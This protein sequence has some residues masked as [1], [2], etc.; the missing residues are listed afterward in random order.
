MPRARATPLI[1]VD[2]LPADG[3]GMEIH[4]GLRD[5]AFAPGRTAGKG[6][7]LQEAIKLTVAPGVHL[8]G[9]V[10][11]DDRPTLRGERGEEGTIPPHAFT[12]G[13]PRENAVEPAGQRHEV[14]AG[15]SVC[16][17]EEPGLA[18]QGVHRGDVRHHIL[19]EARGHALS[20]HCRDP[21]D[22]RW[23]AIGAMHGDHFSEGIENLITITPELILYWL[24]CYVS[25]DHMRTKCCIRRVI[26]QHRHQLCLALA[27]PRPR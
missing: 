26:P 17:A 1:A 12:Q 24:R 20:E 18:Q 6:R 22:L 19:D 7:V 21:R 8:L 15:A 2:D 11:G 23:F 27:A 9:A 14:P 3:A 16:G 13:D 10:Q 25:P 5:S 4:A